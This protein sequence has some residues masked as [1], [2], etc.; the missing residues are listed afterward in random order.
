MFV[1]VLERFLININPAIIMP[2][3]QRD[4][5]EEEEYIN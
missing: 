3:S 4:S 5:P 1:A 2:N